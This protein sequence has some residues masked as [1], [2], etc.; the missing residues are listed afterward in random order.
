[1]NGNESSILMG[2]LERSVNSL[3]FLPPTQ[4]E[5]QAN[6][7]RN[8]D[9]FDE[10]SHEASSHAEPQLRTRTNVHTKIS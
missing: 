6:F 9:D 4:I 8:A 3:S 10:Q 5:S 2:M 7:I 1:M